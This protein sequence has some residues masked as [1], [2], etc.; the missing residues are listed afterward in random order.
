MKG[1]MTL[2]LCLLAALLVTLSAALYTDIRERHQ[3]EQEA[4]KFVQQVEKEPSKSWGNSAKT[5]QNW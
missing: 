1:Y 4:K 5:I 2:K 3:R